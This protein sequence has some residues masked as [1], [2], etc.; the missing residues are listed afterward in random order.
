MPPPKDFVARPIIERLLSRIE[1]DAS[2][3]WIWLGAQDGRGYGHIATGGRGAPAKTHRVAYEHLVG[4]IPTGLSIDHLCRVQLCCNPVHLE[5]VSLAENT[6]RQ[7]AAVGHPNALKTHCPVG[8]A[9]DEANTRFASDG[10][11][12]VCRTCRA[13]SNKAYRE[14]LKRG[15]V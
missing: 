14:R 5:V 1:I 6:R 7:L 8:H 2:G 15:A 9:F 4:P 12:R 13:A 3:C 11:G 10:R